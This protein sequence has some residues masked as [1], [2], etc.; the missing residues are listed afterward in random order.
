M[1]MRKTGLQ[2]LSDRTWNK[3]TNGKTIKSHLRIFFP[4]VQ[5][6]I[7]SKVNLLVITNASASIS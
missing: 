6:Q 7:L 3:V 5:Q 2:N 1:G 4:D